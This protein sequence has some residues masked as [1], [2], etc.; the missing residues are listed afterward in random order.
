MVMALPAGRATMVAGKELVAFEAEREAKVDE[1]VATVAMVATAVNMAET[2]R[3]RCSCVGEEW[4]ETGTDVGHG[5]D[6]RIHH[7]KR[8]ALCC[9][10]P[11][12]T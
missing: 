1:P 11:T 5:K 12:C 10:S 7:S 6:R 3:R 2:D 9:R 8:R 4:E